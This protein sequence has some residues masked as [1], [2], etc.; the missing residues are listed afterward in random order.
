LRSKVLVTGGAGF[1]GSHACKALASAGYEPVVYDNLSTGHRDLVRWGPLEEGDILDGALLD[2]VFSSHEPI[3]VLH[4]AALSVVA[5][6]VREPE[7]YRRN[8]V[9]GSQ[10]LF[11]AMARHGVGTIVFSSTAAVYGEPDV[12]PIHEDVA[13]APINPYGETKLAIERALAAS[14][15]KWMALRYFNAAGADADGE[16]G[17]SHEPETHLIPIVLDVALGRRSTITVFGDDY[18]TPDGTCV[19]DY[20][21]VTD[22]AD[23]HVAALQHLLAGGDSR[24]LNLGT[25]S[26]TS[27]REI[28]EIA[29][30]VTGHAIPETIGPRRSGD[31]PVLVCSN[32]AAGE[33]LGWEPGRGIESQ[34]VDAWRWQQARFGQGFDRS[35]PCI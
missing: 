25:G 16:T 26:G 11:A 13:L 9:E 19:R 3:A 6:S 29:R 32:R 22:L 12:V 1:V 15:L 2:T 20:I 33:T 8:N 31:P 28:I 35:G 10:S 5:E 18:A 17:E 24:A 4:F 27:V 14:D 23:A 34:V 21:H 7:R 30:T